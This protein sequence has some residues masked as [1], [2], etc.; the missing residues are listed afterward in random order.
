MWCDF[1]PQDFKA[2]FRS[3]DFTLQ[4]QDQSQAKA[5]AKEELIESFKQRQGM[6]YLVLWHPLGHDSLTQIEED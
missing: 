6:R 3:C 1:I 5:F 4:S 2:E